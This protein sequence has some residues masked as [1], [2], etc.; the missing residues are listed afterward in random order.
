MQRS[1]LDY[2]GD[3]RALLGL[4][5]KLGE[6]LKGHRPQDRRLVD[7]E[8]LAHK[9]VFH[10]CS[11]LYLFRG[12]RLDDIPEAPVNFVDHA[13]ILA[14]ARP[15][16]ESVWA[17]YH[18]FVEP[19]TEDAIAFRYCC[20]MLA[21]LVQRE[22]FPAITDWGREQLGRDKQAVSR[23]REELESTEAFGSLTLKDKK[24]ALNG[25]LWRPQSLKATAEAFLGKKF[26][27]AIYAWLCSYQHGDALSAIQIRAADSYER[28][29]QMAQ[30][31]LLLAA[32][33]LSQ[34]VKG[35]LRLWPHL[36][37]VIN[38]YP[39]IETL[40]ETYVRFPQ[41]EPDID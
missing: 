37:L 35:Y 6:S 16:L 17:F 7:S 10:T 8:L 32:I 1:G 12:T 13:S 15:L 25:K 11:I 40:V 18:I 28:Q 39:K 22:K 31:S 29:R 34:M 24:K 19:K 20:W 9:I 36:R 30:G 33:S 14:V 23:Y 4:F 5:V 3:C 41:F 2:E 21:G 38:L 26:G 27:A